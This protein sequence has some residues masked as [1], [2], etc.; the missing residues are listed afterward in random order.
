MANQVHLRADGSVDQT[1][2]DLGKNW[3]AATIS[4]GAIMFTESMV[5]VDTE[6]AAARDDL[7]LI[8]DGGTGKMM[9]LRNANAGRVIVLKHNASGGNI[10]SNS[11]DDVLLDDPSKIQ[12][13]IYSGSKWVVMGLCCGGRTNETPIDPEDIDPEATVSCVAATR[14]AAFI[15]T[16]IDEVKVAIEDGKSSL[17]IAGIINNYAAMVRPV[18]DGTYVIR[19]ANKFKAEFADAAAVD[20]EF[21]AEAYE[22]L[23]CIILG[24]D[25]NTDGLYTVAEVLTMTSALGLLGTLYGELFADFLSVLTVQG[26]NN[27]VAAMSEITAGTCGCEEEWCYEFTG[28]GG[29]S[30]GP[31]TGG[32]GYFGVLESGSIRHNDL[33]SP[34][35]SGSY[36]RRLD[37]TMTF[38]SS[39]ITHVEVDYQFQKGSQNVVPNTSPAFEFAVGSGSLANRI[40]AT[41]EQGD[42]SYVW[43]GETTTSFIRVIMNAYISGNASYSGLCRVNRVLVRG[44]GANPFGATNC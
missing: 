7:A 35:S 11:L 34:V 23:I 21:D 6:G 4:S 19:L 43:D 32:A 39:T 42:L 38:T 15:Q 40:W 8:A 24:A 37:M 1:I 9:L 17:F 14:V 22:T 33:R 5:T 2:V 16:T 41:A 28:F 29:W 12:L 3:I 10:Y 36:F 30:L 44:V 31:Q 20:A 18:V 25:S 13:L 26:M 27:S